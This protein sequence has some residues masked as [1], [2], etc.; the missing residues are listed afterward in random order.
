MRDIMLM[1]LDRGRENTLMLIRISMMENIIIIKNMGLER[2]STITIKESIMDNGNS[3]KDM[4][5]DCILMQIR[6][7]TLDNGLRERNMDK[8]LMYLQ[9][10]L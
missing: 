8:A 3:V 2:S 9:T 6:M 10:L 4:E 7:S 1:E 5:K